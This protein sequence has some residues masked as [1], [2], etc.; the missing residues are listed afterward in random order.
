MRRELTSLYLDIL[1]GGAKVPVAHDLGL[2][3]FTFFLIIGL[4]SFISFIVHGFSGFNSM[5]F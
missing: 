1:E 4:V 2:S 5:L 3:H